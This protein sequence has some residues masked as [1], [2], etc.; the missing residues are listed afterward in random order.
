M[1]FSGELESFCRDHHP[2]VLGLLSLYCGERLLAEELAQDALVQVCRHWPT[3]RSLNDPGAWLTTVAL[4]LARSRFRS[5]EAKRR[6]LTRLDARSRIPANTADTADRVAVRTA[7]AAL[8]ERER[9]ALV[10]RYYADLSVR[11][12]A[13]AMKCPEGTVKTLTHQGINRL[14]TAGLE[15]ADD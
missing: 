11:D 5:R 3:V 10:L 15:V 13:A 9:R 12:V 6:A 14:R 7:V 2:R 4:N 1:P 8:P